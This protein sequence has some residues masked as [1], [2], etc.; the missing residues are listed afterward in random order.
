MIIIAGVAAVAVAAH[1]SHPAAVAN[2]HLG[3]RGGGFD[4]VGGGEGKEAHRVEEG[5]DEPHHHL[6]H[7]V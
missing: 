5:G 7:V 2:D 6:W 4:V 3:G 1:G